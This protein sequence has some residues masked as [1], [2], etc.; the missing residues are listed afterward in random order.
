MAETQRGIYYPTKA[1]DGNQPAKV[2]EKLELMAESTDNAI[3]DAVEEA[4]YDDTE[5]KEDIND[6]KTNYVKNTDYATGSKGGI[7]KTNEGWGVKTSYGY[8]IGNTFN[9]SGYNSADNNILIAK[10]TLENVIEGKGLVNNTQLQ[11]LQ[12][13]NEKLKKALPQIKGTGTDIT[14]NNTSDNKF[15]ELGVGGNTEQEQLSGIQLFDKNGEIAYNNFA[16]LTVLDTGIKATSNVSDKGGSYGS[17]KIPNGENLLGEA[18][19]LYCKATP[20]NNRVCRI[21]VAFINS[22]GFFVSQIARLDLSG[23]GT[24]TNITRFNVPSE[25]PTNAVGIA[26]LFYGS[27]TT[28]VQGEYVNYTDVRLYKGSYTVSDIPDYEKYVGGIE[29][30]NPSYE[31]PVKNVTGDVNVKIQNKNLLYNSMLPYTQAGVTISCEN[32][33][34]ELNGT[35]KQASNAY[36]I[37]YAT[38]LMH[39]EAGDSITFY[40][41]R[42]SGTSKVYFTTYLNFDDGSG[43]DYNWGITLNENVNSYKVVK[44]AAKSG[45]IDHVQFFLNKD[46]VYNSKVK[47]LIQKGNITNPSW[48]PHQEQN[49]PFTLGTQR[50]YQGS[51]LAD[52]GI[53]NVKKQIVLDGSNDE[54]WG[55]QSQSGVV[56]KRFTL[57]NYITDIKIGSTDNQT[58][59][60][61]NMF[62]QGNYLRDDNF[63]F[64]VGTRNFVWLGSTQLQEMTLAQFKSLLSENPLI[65]EYETAEE[66][67]EPYNETQQEQYN[68][69]KEAMSY[70]EQ[71]NISSIAIIEANAVGDL[72]LILS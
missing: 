21:N 5:I 62:L 20:N 14:L 58:K 49:L 12:Q 45:Y 2:I 66:W 47:I 34:Y 29:A 70:Y 28:T 19:T 1:V 48:V 16:D 35:A 64:A 15:N 53:H 42:V 51:Y 54:S 22:S 44:T 63:I 40:I 52:D 9:F 33:I 38:P 72:N 39:I 11:E 18:L 41:E 10:G 55:E 69:I 27:T 61:S 4:T 7:V 30:P 37:P 59:V 32:D 71:T 43:Y 67:I 68:A 65:I 36:I 57:N 56:T 13:E 50:L 6:I 26:L 3:N 25:F 46:V 17:I 31:I 8:L 23:T 60:V 24:V